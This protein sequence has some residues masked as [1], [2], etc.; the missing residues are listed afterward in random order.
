MK[1]ERRPDICNQAEQMM[2]SRTIFLCESQGHAHCLRRQ[3][4]HPQLELGSEASLS[5][6]GSCPRCRWVSLPPMEPL[7]DAVTFLPHPSYSDCCPRAAY[8]THQRDLARPLAHIIL[9]CIDQG[10]HGEKSTQVQLI[11]EIYKH[12]EPVVSWLGSTCVAGWIIPH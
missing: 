2:V 9:V 10:H 12:A 1:S 4:M 6:N 11:G 7:R 5:L 8:A 3:K